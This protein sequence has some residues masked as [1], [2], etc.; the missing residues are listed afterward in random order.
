[1]KIPGLKFIYVLFE[2]KYT[3]FFTSHEGYL[4][5]TKLQDSSVGFLVAGLDCVKFDFYQ[6]PFCLFIVV[7]VISIVLSNTNYCEKFIAIGQGKKT[8]QRR[9]KNIGMASEKLCRN[10]LSDNIRPVQPTN[11]LILHKKGWKANL[12]EQ[13]RKK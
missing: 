2:F 8:L 13:I 5:N 7:I 6:F 3:E 11:N 12:H 1:L 10:T 9:L 4:L